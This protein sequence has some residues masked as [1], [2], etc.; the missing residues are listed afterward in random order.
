[1]KHII[2]ASTL[3]LAAMGATA[4]PF[5]FQRQIGS[6]EY[7]AGADTDGMHF[8]RVE[9]SDAVPSLTAWMLDANVDGIAANDFVGSITPSGPS[10]ISL[11]EAQRGSPEA[12]A[13]RGYYERH[14]VGT[15]WARVADE[16]RQQRI[17]GGLAAEPA[18][19]PDAS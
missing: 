15:D 9:A 3:A 11:Y 12:T 5:D 2:I 17:S 18:P 6:S 14:P 4:A 16:F 10:R 19:K 1:M 13:Y 8:A 7:V